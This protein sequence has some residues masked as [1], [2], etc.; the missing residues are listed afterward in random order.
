VLL[1]PIRSLAC[2]LLATS[3][4]HFS[5]G[6]GRVHLLKW[7]VFIPARTR[8]R[9]KLAELPSVCPI[10]AGVLHAGEHS[11]AY[12]CAWRRGIHVTPYLCAIQC[13]LRYLAT[14]GAERSEGKGGEARRSSAAL[15][16]CCSI[17]F[18]EVSALQHPPHWANTPQYLNKII[19]A[20][21]FWSFFH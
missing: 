9:T 2:V 8:P 20:Q 12:C 3:L 18:L 10:N 4:I 1:I 7:T 14:H 6:T 15:H 17:A 5:S 11:V 19:L 13:L 16:C 21:E